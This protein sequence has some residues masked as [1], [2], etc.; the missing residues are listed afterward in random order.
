MKANIAFRIKVRMTWSFQSY[1]QI[2]FWVIT[3]FLITY[4][5][6]LHTCITEQTVIYLLITKYTLL[7]LL[8]FK[9]YRPGQ[10]LQAAKVVPKLLAAS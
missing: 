4:C 3:S 2:C 5:F 6:K 10:G 8:G 1:T 7:L 9:S